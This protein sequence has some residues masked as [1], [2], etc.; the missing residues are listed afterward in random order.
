MSNQ[1]PR[2][3]YVIVR[4]KTRLYKGLFK[5]LSKAMKHAKRTHRA[6]TEA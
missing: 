5:L 2:T 6:T 1:K 4:F 3:L